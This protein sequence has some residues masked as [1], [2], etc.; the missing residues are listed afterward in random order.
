MLTLGQCAVRFGSV[1]EALQ[2]REGFA[3]LGDLGFVGFEF[4]RVHTTTEAPHFYRVLEVKHL[5]VE[6]VFD[7]E[8]G[9]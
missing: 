7:C 2:E 6:K 5:V 9:A 4:A 8:A 3:K 1:L